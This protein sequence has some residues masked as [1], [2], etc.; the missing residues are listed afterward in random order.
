MKLLTA[1]TEALGFEIKVVETSVNLHTMT[2]FHSDGL[3]KIATGLYVKTVTS[4]DYKVT[5]KAKP[6]NKSAEERLSEAT[7]RMG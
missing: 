3:P 1:L 7:G 5:K 4:I 6:I 2:E